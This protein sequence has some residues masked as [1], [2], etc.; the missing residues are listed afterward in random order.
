MPLYEYRCDEDGDLVTLLR[1][2]AQADDPV[3]DPAGRGRAFHRVHSVFQ[4]ETSAPT[5]T[6]QAAAAAPRGGC[7]CHPGGGGCG[8]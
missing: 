1:P 2:M 5:S 8:H 6:G 4:V 3:E 7:A